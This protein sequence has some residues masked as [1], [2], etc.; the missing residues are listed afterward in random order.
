MRA[1]AVELALFG[2]RPEHFDRARA[3]RELDI[4][5]GLLVGGCAASPDERLEALIR[6]CYDHHMS[7]PMLRMLDPDRA[8]RDALERLLEGGDDADPEGGAAGGA[9]AGGGAGGGG[10]EDGP[11][12]PP[13]ADA[14]AWADL[15]AAALRDAERRRRLYADRLSR[16][17]AASLAQCVREQRREL[18]KTLRVNVYGDA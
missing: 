7:T 18:E 1:A 13:P 2:R 14:V 10:G 15:P 9:D 8:N 6:A 17:S 4:I 3:A 16:R 11:G 5:D 12:A